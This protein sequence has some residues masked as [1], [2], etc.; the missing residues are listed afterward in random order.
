[1]TP[2]AQEK[3]TISV[4]A[5][6]LVP[7]TH[8]LGVLDE[9]LRSSR[10]ITEDLADFL[11]HHGSHDPGYDACILTDELSFTALTYRHLTAALASTAATD[12]P[13]RH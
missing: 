11:G 1:M 5:A 6:S 13:A 12:Q 4:P 3:T 7:L 9:F 10:R 8:L 2:P